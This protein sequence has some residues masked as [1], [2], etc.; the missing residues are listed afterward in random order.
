MVL[1]GKRHV[2][3]LPTEAKAMPSTTTTL[4]TEAGATPRAILAT[5]EGTIASALATGAVVTT[6]AT[7][8]V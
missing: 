8:T 5:V 1:A 3:A 2:Q 7:D 4:A 6:L